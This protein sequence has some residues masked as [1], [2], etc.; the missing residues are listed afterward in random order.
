MWQLKTNYKHMKTIKFLLPILL[1]PFIGIAQEQYVDLTPYVVS[2]QGNV[3]QFLANFGDEPSDLEFIT[4]EESEYY[5][6]SLTYSMF[7]D[8]IDGFPVTTISGGGLGSGLEMA[9]VF[10]KMILPKHLTH[11]AISVEYEKM[12]LPEGLQ[13]LYLL[14]DR[15]K[16][17]VLPHS[18]KKDHVLLGWKVYN[19]TILTPAGTHIKNNSQLAIAHAY[20]KYLKDE[21]YTI[22][23]EDVFFIDG[24]IKTCYYRG[25]KNI[26]VPSSFYGHKVENIYN[27]IY[28]IA[29]R[30]QDLE[31]VIFENGFERIGGFSWNKIAHIDLPEGLIEIQQNA[32]FR[33]KLSEVVI[34][35]S[36]IRIEPGAFD[37]NSLNTIKFKPSANLRY[38]NGF[39]SNEISELLLPSS[40]DTIGIGAFARNKIKDLIIPKNVTAIERV[41][42]IINEIENL[43]LPESLDFIGAEA[44]QYN[45]L[46]KVELPN[47]LKKLYE[48]TFSDNNLE[49]VALPQYLEYIGDSCFKNNQLSKVDIPLTVVHI[50]PGAFG[51][52]KIETI[53]LPP[54]L[55]YLSGF[56]KNRISEITLPSGLDTI[57][58]EAFAYNKLK[59]VTIP[60]QVKVI[61]ASAFFSNVLERV[62]LPTSLEYVGAKAFQNNKLS[63]VIIPSQLVYIGENAFADNPFFKALPTLPK[64]TVL[65]RQFLYWKAETI[66]DTG[67]VEK[68]EQYKPGNII[69]N[70]VR[71]TAVFEE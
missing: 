32:F 40:I 30:N 53:K 44:F 66:S 28:E 50:S 38:V 68:V 22:G 12:I 43:E 36:V 67:K 54:N 23:K 58:R 27:D 7:P 63:S 46:T 71:Y 57:G 6:K 4:E 26:I 55:N 31:S 15:Q 59:E 17:F 41:A 56:D 52:N 69:K 39:L 47:G 42:F 33:N 19:D 61:E 1:I 37:N 5:F 24:E 62:E 14:F 10:E 13:Y 9:R 60:G 20:F 51:N 35:S 29:F 21:P 11:L 64:P 45:R 49:F 16:G 2:K 65:G 18:K 3:I 70:E 48:S 34:P 8:S 25:A